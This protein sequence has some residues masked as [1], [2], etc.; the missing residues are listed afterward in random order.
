[1][2]GLSFD[3]MSLSLISFFSYS[4][5]TASFLWIPLF[6]DTYR[7]LHPHSNIPVQINDVF[8]PL[9][10]FAL[11]TIKV[12]QCCV[13]ERGNQRISNTTQQILLSVCSPA[14]VLTVMLVCDQIIQPLAYIYYFSYI[15]IILTAIKYTPQAI[16]NY[17]RKSTEGFAIL[18]I[19]LDF[20]GSTLCIGQMTCLAINFGKHSKKTRPKLW[21]LLRIFLIS[22]LADTSYF[23]YNYSKLGIALISQF[24]D[25]IFIVQHYWL[26]C[27]GKRNEI[28][29]WK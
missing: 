8:F 4:V 29:F 24:F 2:I 23:T 7:R 25:V 14:L 26:Y 20:I 5:F 12:V 22:C 1:M 6:G 16:F 27:Q 19:F 13:Y 9:H 28:F 21:K 18:Q 17:R 15:K 10:Y 11:L 3:S